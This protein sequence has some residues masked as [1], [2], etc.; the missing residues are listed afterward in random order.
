MTMDM[1]ET[2]KLAE[3]SIGHT[4]TERPDPEHFRLHTHDK[5]ELYH[6]VR[7]GGIFHIEGS[8]YPLEPGDLLVMRPAESHYIELDCSQAYERKMIHFDLS[9]LR[10]VD[11]EGTFLTPLLE[12]PPGKQNL[13]RARLFRG[14]S[15]EHYFDAMLCPSGDQ[16]AN[17][18][19]GLLPLLFEMRAI[20]L[21]GSELPESAED[22]VQYRILRYL[23]ENIAG[24]ISLQQIC[25]R[26][27]ISR[28]QLCRLFREATGVTVKQYVTVKRLVTARQRIEAGEPATHVYLQCGFNDYSSFYRAYVKHYGAAPTKTRNG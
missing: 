7:G 25:Q 13:Y 16:R 12:R 21:R 8:V 5:V 27:F 4:V 11:P 28:S 23:N 15:S 9:L 19:A 14:G 24:P 20:S 6:F 3:A 10:Q 22:T 17:V 18:F 1:R 2:V 26:F